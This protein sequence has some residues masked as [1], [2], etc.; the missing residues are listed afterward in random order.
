MSPAPHREHLPVH[1]RREQLLDA[2]I[3]VMTEDGVRG[4]STRTITQRAGLPHG[5]LHYC[6]ASKNALFV[7]LLEREVSAVLAGAWPEVAE[8]ADAR[9]AF[10]VAVLR[11]LE[12]VM[13]RTDYHLAARELVVVVARQAPPQSA[14][15]RE[16]IVDHI[17]E[18]LRRWSARHDLRWTVPLG[19]LAG[20][21]VVT[22]SGLTETWL[23][24]RDREATLTTAR[25]AAGTLAA[26]RQDVGPGADPSG[27]RREPS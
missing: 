16:R 18:L 26:L 6:F 21:L 8:V 14:A 23:V 9:A 20:V 5:A 4:T 25:A 2:A 22:V 19:T 1:V 27:P 15:L 3:A 12:R 7:A 24:T 10:E 17:A 13:A 11:Y